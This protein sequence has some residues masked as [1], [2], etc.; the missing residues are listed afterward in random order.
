MRRSHKIYHFDVADY[1]GISYN[2]TMKPKETLE[3]FDAFLAKHGLTLEAIVI[4]GAA[5][6][7][8]DVISRETRDCELEDLQRRLGR[9]V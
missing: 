1:F 2:D 4:G 7:L 6:G 5:L 9:G 8:L 3:R